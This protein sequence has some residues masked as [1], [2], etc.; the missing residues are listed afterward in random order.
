MV[1]WRSGAV[2]ERQAAVC[3]QPQAGLDQR[4]ARHRLHFWPVRGGP[5]VSRARLPGEERVGPVRGVAMRGRVCG[6]VLCALLITAAAPA[7]AQ[8]RMVIIDQD[9]SGPGGSNIMSMMV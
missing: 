5:L 6:R 8:K 7:I 1:P 4:G 9:G 3:R 2:E